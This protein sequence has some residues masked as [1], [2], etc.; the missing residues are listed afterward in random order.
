MQD[1]PCMSRVWPTHP[2][3]WYHNYFKCT[4]LLVPLMSIYVINPITLAGEAS[5]II[6]P[7]ETV[8]GMT[9][10]FFL[11][12]LSMILKRCSCLV[13]RSDLKEM[14]C[15]L[16][17]QSGFRTPW[18]KSWSVCV[19]TAMDNL[20]TWDCLTEQMLKMSQ[21]SKYKDSNFYWGTIIINID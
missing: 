18:V 3:H 4:G 5:A 1:F 13:Y 15:P 9:F 20:M 11:L 21:K 17:Q 2:L 10:F 7:W 19:V 8:V 12:F 16:S 6:C 14:V